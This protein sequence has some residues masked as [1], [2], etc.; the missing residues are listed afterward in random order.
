MLRERVERSLPYSPEQLFDLAADVERYPEFLR[1]WIAARVQERREE[2]YYTDQILGLGPIRVRF[3]SKTV[4]RRPDRID[5]TSDQSPF[6]HFGLSWVFAPERDAG[7]RVGLEVELEFKSRLLQMLV[8]KVLLATIA[9]IVAAFEG[10]AC[11][12]YGDMQRTIG[13]AP[14][15]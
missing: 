15:T 9:D 3:K 4:L 2:V 11:S 6:R 12:L 14:C 5:V 13:D 7:C 10:R 8:E 1:W